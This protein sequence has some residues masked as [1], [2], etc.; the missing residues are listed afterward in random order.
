METLETNKQHSLLPTNLNT[1]YKFKPNISVYGGKG[2]YSPTR[3]LA[4]VSTLKD[5]HR[6]HPVDI[7]RRQVSDDSHR[8]V[9]LR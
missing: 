6:L 7:P 5:L 1:N 3:P 2:D 8:E 9:W 4:G